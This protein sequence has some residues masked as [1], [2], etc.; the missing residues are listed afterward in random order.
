MND[1]TV[2]ARPAAPFVQATLAYLGPT[3]ERPHNYACEPPQGK[4]WENYQP[5]KRAV[6]IRDGRAMALPATLDREGFAL[7]DAPSGV[8]DFGDVD[9]VKRVYYRELVLLAC[10][11]TG[12]AQAHVFDHLI[13]RR[14]AQGQPLGFGRAAK[15]VPA[16][17]NGSVHNDYTE[18]SGRRR[19]E[20]VLGDMAPQVAGRR[21]AI[22]NIWRSIRAPVLDTPL[23]VCDARSLDAADLVEAEVRYPRRTGEIYL[24]RHSA[25]HRWFYF[26]AMDV[27]EAL[28]FKQY[29]SQLGGV[30]RFTPHAAFDHPAAPAGA[31]PRVSIE[32]RCLVIH[33]QESP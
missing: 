3:A 6:D 32:A 25:R 29:D 21:Y 27:H 15:G 12:A 10:A 24:A 23:A 26:S 8:R 16:S 20:L 7:W 1:R 28:V 33:D 30:A 19:L 13:R 9:E 31:I 11:A 18:A 5:D 17:A 14:D 2:T 4:P 22:V